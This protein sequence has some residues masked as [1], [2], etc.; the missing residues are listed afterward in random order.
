[1]KIVL[2]IVLFF[3]WGTMFSQQVSG[4]VLNK[5]NNQPIEFVNIGIV[6]K[7]IGTVSNIDGRF[8]IVIDSASVI[9][10]TL[11]FSA[12]GYESKW[13]QISNLLSGDKPSVRLEK[14]SYEIAEVVVSPTKIKEKILGVKTKNKS[15]SAGFDKNE[16]GYEL[17]ILMKVKKRAILKQVNINIASCS[18]DSIHFR[19]NIYKV[20]ENKSFENILI[21][22]IYIEMPR[23]KVAEEI[24][25]DLRGKN[26]NVESN[27][28]I[29]LEHIKN[30]GEGHL[31]FCAALANKTHYRKTSQGKW[32]TVGIGVSISVLADVEK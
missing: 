31:H 30:L 27:F 26:I 32:E 6:D 29:T 19:L 28:L 7:N 9:N 3:C 13:I 25:V 15:I 2:F 8:S 20:K 4:V 16:L 23:E 17:G 10:D 5:S 21:E 18:Y 1:M 11:L 12:I 22:P 14:K 24:E